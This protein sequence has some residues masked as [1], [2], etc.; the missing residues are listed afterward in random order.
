MDIATQL[1]DVFYEDAKKDKNFRVLNPLSPTRFL[2]Y[3]ASQW[4]S[5]SPWSDVRVRKAASLAIDR[6]TL[7][8]VHMPGAG[9]IGSLGLTGD[10]LAVQFPPDPYDPAMAKK[11]LAEAGYPNGFHGGKFYPYDGP[12]R[13]FGE[14]V[15]TYLRSI[16]IRL[17]SVILERPAWMANRTSGKMRGAVFTDL[18][19]APT[20][21]GRLSYLFGSSSLG[22]YPDIQTLWDRFQSSHSPKMR[23]DLIAQV[24]K[25]IYEK[26]MYIPL[27]STTTP[28]ALSPK[29]KGNPIKIQP[30]IWFIAPLEDVEIVN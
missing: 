4:D 29:V 12:Y 1:T 18:S 21:A 14:Q 6:K 24:Q 15:A 28:A 5:K 27:T 26:R 17:D 9:P 8:D 30:L 22:N 13:A 11:L 19:V 10:P 23:K 3:M 25:L 7:A 2:V 20:I 16:G